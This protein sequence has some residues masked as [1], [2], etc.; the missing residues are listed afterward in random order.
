MKLLT[1]FLFILLTLAGLVGSAE[2]Q[3]YSLRIKEVDGFPNQPGVRTL[4]VSNGSL[5]C[6]GV[7]CTLTTGTGTGD[8]VG[9]ASSTD[10]AVVRF[11]STTGKL[12]QNSTA[13]LSDA[14]AFAAGNG[15]AVLPAYSFASDTTTGLYLASG[16]P[17]ISVAGA[18]A[19]TFTSGTIRVASTSGSITFGGDVGFARDAAGVVRTSDASTNAGG[20]LV[21]AAAA[22]G[23]AGSLV[24]ASANADSLTVG[25]NGLTNPAFQVVGNVASAATGI[26]ITGRA[27]GAGVDITVLSSGANEN[28]VIAPKGTG[29]LLINPT[30]GA[31]GIGSSSASSFYISPASGQNLVLN[32]SGGGSVQSQ[33]SILLTDGTQGLTRPG[34]NQLGLSAGGATRIVVGSDGATTLTSAAASAFSIGPNGD[35][36]PV[37]RVVGNVASAATGLSVTGNAAGSGVTLTALS[38]GSDEPI[39]L[40]PKG[41]ALIQLGGT[42]SSFPAFKIL[43]GG[44]LRLVNANFSS[45]TSFYA[46]S[47]LTPNDTTPTFVANSDGTVG[48]YSGG[49]Y[50]WTSGSVGTGGRDTSLVR[51]AAATVRVTNASTGAGNFIVGTSAGA[52]GT[53]GAGVLAFAASTIPSTSPADTVQF[54]SGDSAAGDH[55]VYTRNEAGEV[56]RLTGLTARNSAQF[57]KTSDT[58]L[59]NVT[60]LTRNIEAARAYAFRAVIATT[61]AATGGVKLAVSG[62]ATATAIFYE[63][64]LETGAAIIAKT[65][66]TA[67]DTT[68]CA[69]TTTTAGTCR[70]E[71]VIVV[72]TGGTLTIQF[73]QN[74][75]DGG[76]SSVL[77]NQYFQLIPIS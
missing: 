59:A 60:G 21:G 13:T 27:A 44:N 24:V 2:A 15:S 23:T 1:T 48:L 18:L 3:S 55:N 47:L 69:S 73:A 37:F 46:N 64:T 75:S 34:A 32:P 4:I 52:I 66:A 26:S 74:A 20:L 11:D 6:T 19:H 58:T 40:V 16:N 57:D 42:S 5:S 38:S 51:A 72:N 39:T 33:S 9:P 25:P 22:T 43:S 53:S 8:V 17:A 30:T 35:T 41:T 10:N 61:A 68:V 50:G 29:S 63:G 70:I 67:L 7:T 14:G 12:I 65:R 56:N 49:E 31:P 62:T 76:A 77:A 36:N 28:I 54:Y 71:G 45:G